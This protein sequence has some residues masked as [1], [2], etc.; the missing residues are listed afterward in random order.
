M[1]A[2]TP[3]HGATIV[4]RVT[5][6]GSHHAQALS[7][8][9]DHGLFHRRTESC[10][11][12]MIQTRADAGADHEDAKTRREP[13]KSCGF[14]DMVVSDAQMVRLG[15]ECTCLHTPRYS[16]VCG[17][18][19]IPPVSCELR[20]LPTRAFPLC[21]HVPHRRTTPRRSSGPALSSR[22]AS[23][24]SS[25]GKCVGRDVDKPFICPSDGASSSGRLPRRTRK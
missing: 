16:A 2:P 11:R 15:E 22:T 17:G 13:R 20:G 9:T 23:P 4:R 21:L 7:S 18:D 8:R 3:A 14:N 24:S 12:W 1:V 10:S 25:T 5:T 19:V 6:T